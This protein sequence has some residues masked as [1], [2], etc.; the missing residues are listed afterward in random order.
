MSKRRLLLLSIF[1]STLAAQACLVAGCSGDDNLE[2]DDTSDAAVDG[3]KSDATTDATTIGDA[4]SHD[5]STTD[6]TLDATSDAHENDATLTDTNDSDAHD[7]AE[8]DASDASFEDASDAGAAEDANDGAIEDAAT[9][10]AIDGGAD[11]S[12]AGARYSHTIAIDGVN[13]FT[14]DET[15]A[16]TSAGYTGY[17]AWDDTYLYVGLDGSDVSSN[18]A[19]KFILVYI[20]GTA[21]TTTGVT[22]NTQQPTL[23]F[24][25]AYN[26]SWK[27]DNS[28][29]DALAWSG[30]AWAEANWNFTGDVFQ[31]GN[32]FEM[33]IPLVN[34]GSPSSVS[35]DV[36]MINATAFHEA[37]YSGV[38]ST[39]FTDG[40][41]PS[42]AEY[43]QL[44]LQ[45][46]T[47]PNASPVLP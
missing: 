42:Y 12:D 6:A 43:L 15:F 24:P 22:Y 47:V 39:S 5:A 10:A 30:T 7:A 13:D 19:N 1:A 44:D 17:L 3:G 27:A 40:Y 9:D 28:L 23:A 36:S 31:N 4:S 33:R 14:A 37:T 16:T 35:V 34:I 38:P 41:N 46:S 29:T 11:A 45:G 2:T 25:A 32:Y 26:V 21:G 8:T 18:D 20:S